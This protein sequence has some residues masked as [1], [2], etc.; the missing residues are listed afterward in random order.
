MFE[1]A[2][3]FEESMMVRWPLFMRSAQGAANGARARG[4]DSISLCCCAVAP[5]P[6][7]AALLANSRLPA[8]QDCFLDLSGL[9]K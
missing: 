2:R 1:L 8:R 9:E 6:Q 7:V 3:G 5:A 4:M